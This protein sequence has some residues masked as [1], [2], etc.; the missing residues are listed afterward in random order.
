MSHIPDAD[1][2]GIWLL[3]PVIYIG[4]PPPGAEFIRKK[5]FLY[6]ELKFKLLKHEGTSSTSYRI[7]IDQGF[8]G[9]FEH[10]WFDYFVT[11]KKLCTAL[12]SLGA[13][14]K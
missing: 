13:Q 14:P 9:A 8:I 6:N 4:N 3:N 1:E 12:I 7:F 11:A 10:Y 2:F 5:H